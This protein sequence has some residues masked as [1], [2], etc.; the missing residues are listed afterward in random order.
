MGLTRVELVTSRLS[1]ARSNQLSYRPLVA[2]A[3]SQ[4]I[5]DQPLVAWASSKRS[6]QLAQMNIIANAQMF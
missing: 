4:F 5:D 6:L 1:G 2:W 3:S